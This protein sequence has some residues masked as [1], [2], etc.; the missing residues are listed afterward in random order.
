MYSKQK[1][2]YET[3]HIHF[4]PINY[5]KTHESFRFSIGF[6]MSHMI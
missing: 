4:V 3:P 2:P 1:Y 5:D 6:G